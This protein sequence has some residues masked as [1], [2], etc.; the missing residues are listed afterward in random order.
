M[1]IQSRLVE[2]LIG[3]Q[4]AG[5]RRAPGW[6]LCRGLYMTRISG[7]FQLPLDRENVFGSPPK[8]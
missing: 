8:K 7:G 2:F 5:P 6:W 1:S 4:A 3:N